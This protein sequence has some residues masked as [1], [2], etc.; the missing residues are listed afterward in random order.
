V[1]EGIELPVFREA[2]FRV[3]KDWRLIKLSE[4]H[5]NWG[6]DHVV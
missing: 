6:I 2:V 5:V 1:K 4:E 3:E